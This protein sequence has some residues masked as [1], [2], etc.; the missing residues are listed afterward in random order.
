[1][2]FVLFLLTFLPRRI[3]AVERQFHHNL[4]MGRYTAYRDQMLASG[5]RDKTELRELHK[6]LRY[7]LRLLSWKDRRRI[8]RFEK[9]VLK[10]RGVPLLEISFTL[11]ETEY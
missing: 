1:M 8:R 10:L 9:G 11:P 5:F 4:I 2:S 7:N 3:S 6:N